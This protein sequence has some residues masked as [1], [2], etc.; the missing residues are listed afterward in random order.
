MV[1]HM[2][3]EDDGLDERYVGSR[4]FRRL[5][6][7]QIVEVLQDGTVEN[8]FTLGGDS[9]DSMTADFGSLVRARRE[10]QV[11]EG[12]RPEAQKPAEGARKEGAEA[13]PEPTLADK[14]VEYLNKDSGFG[15]DRLRA[16]KKPSS[17][18]VLFHGNL[19]D[20]L[21]EAPKG[22]P[23]GGSH[24]IGGT[25][26]MASGTALI[27][28]RTDPLKEALKGR[29]PTTYKE[30]MDKVLALRRGDSVAPCSMSSTSR[31]SPVSAARRAIRSRRL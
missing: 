23:L 24:H 17:G 18:D 25:Q 8:E 13:Q 20:L 31:K 14:V 9:F 4:V 5:A 21:E 19:K 10:S 27:S 11:A 26:K 3:K 29:K 30:H 28:G 22:T 7:G 6:D 16:L 15:D 2:P 12:S 1:Y